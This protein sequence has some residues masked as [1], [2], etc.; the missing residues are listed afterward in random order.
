MSWWA[1]VPLR[2]G[3]P[4]VRRDPS[5]PAGA[6]VTPLAS[7][8]AIPGDYY[9]RGAGSV[10]RVRRGILTFPHRSRPS[11]RTAR[12]QGVPSARD[13]AGS[14]SG[15][16]SIQ[17]IV[18][19][20]RNA[21][22][23]REVAESASGSRASEI[24]QAGS[25]VRFDLRHISVFGSGDDDGDRRPGGARPRSQEHLAPPL[26]RRRPVVPTFWVLRAGRRRRPR[27]TGWRRRGRSGRVIPAADRGGG[28]PMV[29]RPGEMP[30]DAA[31]GESV[32]PDASAG[33]PA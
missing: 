30:P 14:A 25:V 6:P 32:T 10:N 2:R 18:R 21:G 11:P 5:M 16:A 26:K 13:E 20:D 23:N 31:R 33:P 15:A 22:G 4:R 28:G 12:R 19:R 27:R 24:A 29:R 8:R 3:L 1:C 7:N 9:G 17:N